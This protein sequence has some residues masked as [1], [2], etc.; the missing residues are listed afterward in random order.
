MIPAT[1]TPPSALS[2]L[3]SYSR[4]QHEPSPSSPGSLNS[5]SS[6]PHLQPC[7]IN[8]GSCGPGFLLP[9][10][11][12]LVTATPV[13]ST[14]PIDPGGDDLLQP[15]APTTQPQPSRD[16]PLLQ[17]SYSGTRLS[18]PAAPRFQSPPALR[19]DPGRR[20][21][22]LQH[23]QYLITAMLTGAVQVTTRS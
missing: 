8:P 20:H 22:C 21:P 17:P 6:D 7:V 19:P 5:G 15:R 1:V 13:P 9:G 23:S 4:S 12:I 10:S 3:P 18:G 16:D 11:P 2:S 14:M